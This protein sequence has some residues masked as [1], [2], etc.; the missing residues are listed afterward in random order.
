MNFSPKLK[1]LQT[2]PIFQDYF[3]FFKKE[4]KKKKK[5]GVP[6]TE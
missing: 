3:F 2:I 4:R 6:V 5:K 1:N